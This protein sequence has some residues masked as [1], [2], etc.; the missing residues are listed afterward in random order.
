MFI[1]SIQ[2]N[3]DICTRQLINY[4]VGAH[5]EQKLSRKK[6]SFQFSFKTEDQ[7]HADALGVRSR[8]QTKQSKV[9]STLHCGGQ[10][11]YLHY[12]THIRCSGVVAAI[13]VILIRMLFNVAKQ[14]WSYL[15]MYILIPKHP[16][17]T[18][19]VFDPPM[20]YRS[21]GSSSSSGGWGSS[22]MAESL[23]E[24][25]HEAAVAAAAAAA[26]GATA[27]TAAAAAAAAAAQ[28]PAKA[29]AC[30]IR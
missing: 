28:E 5:E 29:T 22:S 10:A 16:M 3:T 9:E 30:V 11:E 18:G 24:W 21:M 26:G 4:H 13:L 6:V 19:K 15:R 23:Q 25:I 8:L 7:G 14:R 12:L 17:T 1:A 27:A 2:F 20:S